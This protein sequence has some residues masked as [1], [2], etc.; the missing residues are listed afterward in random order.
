MGKKDERAEVIGGNNKDRYEHTK[1]SIAGKEQ[2][3][4]NPLGLDNTGRFGFREE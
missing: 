3:G 2:T 4:E 1:E